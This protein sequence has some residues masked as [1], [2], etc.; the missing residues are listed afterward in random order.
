M[1]I[2]FAHKSD[3][4]SMISLKIEY[5]QLMNVYV[6]VIEVSIWFV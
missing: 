1:Y 3:M 2:M 6:I 5:K 4:S